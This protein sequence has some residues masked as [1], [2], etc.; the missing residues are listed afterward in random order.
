MSNSLLTILLGLHHAQ[1]LSICHARA[2]IGFPTPSAT[3]IRRGIVLL[4]PEHLGKQRRSDRRLA[5]VHEQRDQRALEP[6]LGN[7]V[8][9]KPLAA[10][11][12]SDAP[13]P[14]GPRELFQ[15]ARA[16]HR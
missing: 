9:H 2:A 8:A 6:Q 16:A 4:R 5:A 13:K 1:L 11:C 3:L 10:L 14:I 7:L 12:R 15:H